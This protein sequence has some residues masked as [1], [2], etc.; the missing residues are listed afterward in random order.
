MTSAA[1]VYDA[2]TTSGGSGGP[3]VNLD[4]EVIAVNMAILPEF[5]GSN[6]GV[7][8]DKARELLAPAAAQGDHWVMST[9][10]G[11]EPPFQRR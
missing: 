3:V 9:S 6:L 8:I 7:P 10:G 2:D 11:V 5:G 1:V 4:G